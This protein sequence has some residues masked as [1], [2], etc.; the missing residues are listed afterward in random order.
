MTMF[1]QGVPK[2]LLG[3]ALAGVISGAAFAANSAHSSGGCQ[4][5]HH[6]NPLQRLQSQLSLSP[7]QVAQLKPTFEQMRLEH[8]AD[9]VQFESQMQAILTPDQLAKMQ[10]EGEHHGHHL[11]DLNL[12]SDQR[13]QLKTMWEK[14][15][16]KMAAERQQFESQMMAVLTPEQQLK[17]AKMQEHWRHHQHS[18][19]QGQ[20]AQDNAGE[21]PTN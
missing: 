13:A 21:Q 3:L 7:Q 9:H 6:H 5:H 19:G 12:S 16:P 17:F 10:A 8:K 4:G 1:Q 14:N 11:R 15:R 20:H 2:T 18:D